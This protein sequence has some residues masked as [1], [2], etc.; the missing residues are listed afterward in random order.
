MC[1]TVCIPNQLTYNGFT[2]FA[3]N[4]DRPCNEAQYYVYVPAKDYTKGSKVRCTYMEIDQI[5]H[6][7]A[8]ILSKPHWIWG[9]E[10]GTNEFGVTIG[11]EALWT[12][13]PYEDKG[14][15]GMDLLRL[16]L[17]RSKTAEDAFQIL[18]DL[19]EKHKQG[20]NCIKNGIS[21]YHN[22][23][24]ICDHKEAWVLE[25][26][27]KYWIAE[28]IKGI[29]PLSN[30]LS[31]EKY[32]RIH[33]EAIKNAVENGW[34]K[35]EKNFL[36]SNDYLDHF[37][38]FNM[39]A[40][41]R[42]GCIRRNASI[43]NKAK[44]EDLITALRS[45]NGLSLDEA[46]TS[47]PC[48]HAGDKSP[49]KSNATLIAEIEKD[50]VAYWGTGMSTPCAAP[51]KPFWFDAFPDNLIYAYDDQ[52]KALSDWYYR[53]QIS[54]FITA[55]KIDENVYQDEMH[56]MEKQWMTEYKTVKSAS[57]KKRQAFCN[58]VSKEEQTFIEKWIA[59]GE[60]GH[61]NYKGSNEY[62]SWWKEQNRELGQDR[63]IFY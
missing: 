62:Q 3:K 11:N 41:L 55:G 54:R 8:I 7:N 9:G 50:H 25:T 13:S 26:S 51:M 53:E 1:D 48:M 36:W 42:S 6:T 39:G 46:Y 20:G 2:L 14:L 28:K 44:V 63:Q 58:R 12:K 4:S 16:A 60:A 40:V 47:A 38:P 19:L 52:E 37:S 15:L 34:C 59:I 61:A 21:E 23:F 57:Q 43:E 31:I 56:V 27:G 17:E 24:I 35:S 32:D 45:H 33:S 18:I 29:R 49:W 22:G 10:M 5:K 30:V